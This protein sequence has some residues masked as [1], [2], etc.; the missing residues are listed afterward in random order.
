MKFVL[1]DFEKMHMSE[2]HKKSLDEATKPEIDV[3]EQHAQDM[4][5]PN[6]G[7]PDKTKPKFNKEQSNEQGD[8][9]LHAYNTKDTSDTG[10]SKIL[11]ENPQKKVCDEP[12]DEGNEIEKDINISIPN[13]NLPEVVQPVSSR[14]KEVNKEC[15][16]QRLNF[17]TIQKNILKYEKG[18]TDVVADHYLPHGQFE[19]K[20]EKIG[21]FQ[22]YKHDNNIYSLSRSRTK[23]YLE[24]ENKGDMTYEYCS[25][26][27]LAKL[28]YGNG[29]KVKI[30]HNS[31]IQKLI[32]TDFTK[33]VDERDIANFNDLNIE[34]KQ[35][36]IKKEKKND[37]DILC[38]H[39][40]AKLN[41]TDGSIPKTEFLEYLTTTQK[42]PIVSESMTRSKRQN[43]NVS[44]RNTSI[45]TGNV[46]NQNMKKLTQQKHLPFQEV[47]HKIENY[48]E[49]MCTSNFTNN[50]R[51]GHVILRT[52]TDKD[53]E[54][55]HTMQFYRDQHGCYQQKR[56]YSHFYIEN[57]ES[58]KNKFKYC[59]GTKLD[60]LRDKQG[61]T[62]EIP[63]LNKVYILKVREFVH[64]GKEIPIP[65]EDSAE[66]KKLNFKDKS[67]QFRSAFYE[68]VENSTFTKHVYEVSKP[69]YLDQN[70]F[71]EYSYVEYIPETHARTGEDKKKKGKI[72][73][74]TKSYT[75]CTRKKPLQKIKRRNQN[76]STSSTDNSSVKKKKGKY[77]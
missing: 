26:N 51:F 2:C 30:D 66:Y 9:P 28:R 77:D 64:L 31:R 55:I 29:K 74:N 42:M 44:P 61:N 67:E 3:N 32:S 75:Y 15:K 20:K 35:A 8:K 46:S 33:V 49:N 4:N 37:N 60:N 18:A 24:K 38:I 14:Y 69:V 71:S 68:A 54:K 11:G 56:C 22:V 45:D 52:D 70:D 50:K 62:V 76:M 21:Q 57:N 16:S 13:E 25:G 7:K 47:L 27:T 1:K 36:W 12:V 6:F 58:L 63:D 48:H 59:V 53:K 41:K 72:S 39:S 43:T 23:Y 73:T 34:E 17:L 65:S 19:T 10:K 40:I 5:S